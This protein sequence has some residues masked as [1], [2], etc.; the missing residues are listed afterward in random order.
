M[1][2]KANY[3]GFINGITKCILVTILIGA[4][5][6]PSLL[7]SVLSFHAYVRRVNCFCCGGAFVPAALVCTYLCTFIFYWCVGLVGVNMHGCECFRK[8]RLSR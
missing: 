2:S 4:S 8:M 7:F 1:V 5:H 3:T 6:V